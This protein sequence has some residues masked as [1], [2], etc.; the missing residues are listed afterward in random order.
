[1]W[2]LDCSV[3]LAWGLPDEKSR[4]ADRFWS[5]MD[6]NGSVW[7]PAIFWFEVANAIVTARRRKRITDAQAGMMQ[8]LFSR[9][10]ARTDSQA[11]Q[12]A[13]AGLSST[14]ASHGLSAYDAAYLELACRRGF[15]LATLDGKLKRAAS[16]AGVDVFTG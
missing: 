10:P 7:V 5:K 8:D 9:I 12:G 11:T 14:G 2:V 3:A 4:L 16:R 6:D 13:L 1:M 15:S